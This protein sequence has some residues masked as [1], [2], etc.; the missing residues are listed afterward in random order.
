L[1]LYLNWWIVFDKFMWVQ[2]LFLL[3]F[4]ANEDHTHKKGQTMMSSLVFS[5]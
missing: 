2:S 4:I 1:V 5:I 3:V